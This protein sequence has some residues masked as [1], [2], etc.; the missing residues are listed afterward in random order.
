MRSRGIHSHGLAPVYAPRGTIIA[1]ATSPGQAACEGIG[2]NGYFTSALLQHI[3]TQN[4]TIEDL[5]KRVRNTLSASTSGKQTS[6]EHTSLMG[7]FFF[8]TSVLT[9]EYVAEY[10]D[11]ARAD[12]LFD[13]SGARSI[14]DIIRRLKS[15]NWYVQNPAVGEIVPTVL[16]GADKEALFVLGRNLYQSA[17]GGSS[18]AITA[19]SSIRDFLSGFEREIAFHILN[20]YL[21][22]IYFDSRGRLRKDKK[23][24]KAEMLFSLEEDVD[25][26]RSFEFIR[27]SLLFHQKQL[28]YLPGICR[29]LA[30]DVVLKPV[31]SDSLAVVKIMVEGQ[32]TFYA[33]DGATLVSSAS[34]L[35]L[36]SRSVRQFE[37]EV[38]EYMV[39]PGKR[40]QIS[41]VP[42][43][44]EGCSLLLP[45][46]FRIQRMSH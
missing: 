20:G 37:Q 21:Y 29:D 19:L 15:H 43:L 36:R 16:D 4:I 38:L 24:Q 18:A 40:L 2:D 31:L 23:I 10:S 25:Y 13:T 1:F 28:F 45:Y 33:N 8:H 11:E 14:Y 32:D 26:A 17:C 27:Q 3:D 12:A 9:G 39:L 5:L 22:E 7:D 30:V 42:D 6:W 35:T 44:P 46:E 41:Y 34:N